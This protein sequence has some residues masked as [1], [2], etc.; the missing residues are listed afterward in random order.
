MGHAIVAAGEQLLPVRAEAHTR[1]LTGWRQRL[2][3]RLAGNNIPNLYLFLHRH[4]EPTVR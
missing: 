2:G 1:H 3:R 4:D